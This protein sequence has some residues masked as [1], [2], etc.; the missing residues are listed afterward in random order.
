MTVITR[1]MLMTKVTITD[2][3]NQAI[4]TSSTWPIKS[5]EDIQKIFTTDIRI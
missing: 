3:V 1:I 5:R 4:F 2:T